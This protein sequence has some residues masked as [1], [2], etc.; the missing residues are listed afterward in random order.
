MG[1]YVFGWSVIIFKPL[2]GTTIQKTSKALR[3]MTN[4]KGDIMKRQIGW[5]LEISHAFS[6]VM[7]KANMMKKHWLVGVVQVLLIGQSVK[8]HFYKFL[9]IFN[10]KNN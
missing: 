3:D 6:K 7:W 5:L 8:N 4:V 2:R 9:F 1:P 10:D